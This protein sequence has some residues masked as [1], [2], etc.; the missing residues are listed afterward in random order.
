MRFA[1]LSL[2][3]V[4]MAW[5]A[6]VPSQGQRANTLTLE[7][8]GRGTIVIRL[9]S[10]KAPKTTERITQLAQDGF[11]NGQRFHRVIT[12]PRPFLV[13]VGAPSSKTKSMDDESLNTEGTGKTIAYEDSGMSNDAAG[14]VGLSA[15]PGD[16]NSGDCQFYIL[17]APA[18]FLDGSYTVFGRVTQGLDVLRK[19]EKG[20]RLSRVTVQSS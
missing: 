20:D 2:V 12:T 15:K 19:I 9:F 3:A 11:Y 10:Q 17:L 5:G 13:Q 1:R 14:I 6:L 16:R 18:K 8:E 7:V 4:L